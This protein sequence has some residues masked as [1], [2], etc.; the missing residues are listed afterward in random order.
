MGFFAHHL[1][2]V[3]AGLVRRAAAPEQAGIFAGVNP[4]KWDSADPIKLWVIQLILIISMTQFLALIGSRIRQPRVIA[5]VIGGV[6]LGPSIMGR[7]PNFSQTIFPQESLPPLNLTANIGLVLFLFLIGLEV[8]VRLLKR[9]ARSSAIISIAGLVVPLGLGAALAVPIYKEFIDQSV[10]FGQFVL[11][12]AVAIG[13]TAFP[14]LCRI[15]TETRLLDTHVGVV[16]LSAGV[17]NDVVGWVLLALTVALVNSGG[18][19]S[20]LN[21]LYILLTAVGYT[22]FLLFPVRWGFRW[23][24]RRSG[25]LENGKPT[26]LLMTL[27]MI[28]VFFSAFFTDII[29]VHAIFG[30]FL[31]GLIIPKDNGFAISIVEKIEDLISVVFLPLYFALSGLR[32]NLGLLDNGVTWGYTIL[33]I[34]VAFFSKFLGCSIAAKFTGFNLR[35][36]GAIGILMSCKGLVELIV[37]NVGLSA[38]ILDT[39]TFSMFVLHALVVTFI[40]TPLT[41]WVYPPKHRTV[42]KHGVEGGHDTEASEGNSNGLEEVFKTRFTVVLDRLEQLPAVMTLTQLLRISNPTSADASSSSGG[43]EKELEG[44]QPELTFSVGTTTPRKPISINALRLME[45]ERTSDVF[46]SHEVDTLVHTDPLLSVVRTFGYL[47]HMRV[48][49]SLNIIPAEE[50][51]GR[52]ADHVRETSSQLVILPWG[53]GTS[54]DD[55]NT[56]TSLPSPTLASTPFDKLFNRQTSGR[57][58][59]AAVVHTQFVRKVFTETPADVAL[60]IDRGFP[61][62][63]NGQSGTHLFLPFFGGQDDRLAL[64]FVV[65]LCINPSVSATVVRFTKIESDELSPFSTIDHEKAQALAIPSPHNTAFADTVY[66]ARDTQT[67]L[68]SDTADNILWERFTQP[69]ESELADALRRISFTRQASSS[70]LHAVLESAAATVTQHGTQSRVTVV[71]GRSRRMAIESHSVELKALFAERGVVVGSELPRTL[72]DIGAAIAWTNANTSMLV[73]QA[74]AS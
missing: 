68:A 37:L 26:P 55:S 1:R 67:R 61:S 20:G 42:E 38:K 23:V 39:R 74:C 48:S 12:V 4:S 41:L 27:T 24:A 14:V 47:N 53:S 63:Y 57:E 58:Q 46:K 34:V 31:A 5:E 54:I 21:A 65:Q 10:K 45:L 71:V 29:G 72:G 52:V 3:S 40:T 70:P 18:S 11:F 13:I 32:T 30:G 36:S 9:N 17:G 50:F 56:G 73:V 2:E 49:T 62:A 59:T 51:S 43:H 19:G 60:Y 33:I 15:L 66:G 22:L 35:E 8:D 64:S 25:S 7:I 44:G 16:V 6:I 28:L 69:T